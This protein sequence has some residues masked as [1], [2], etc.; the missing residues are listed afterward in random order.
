MLNIRIQFLKDEIN[1][2]NHN[3][4]VND[5]PTISDYEYD[6]LFAELKQIEADHPE[7]ITPDSPTQRVGSVSEKFL[8][9]THTHR[10]YSL[11]NTYNYEDLKDW[12]QKI[13]KE[14]GTDVELVCELKID[15]LAIA[16]T[17]ENGIFTRGVTRGDG[18]TGE[19][20]TQNLKTIKAIPLKLK[21]NVNL[22]VRGEIY[23]PK[24]SFEKLNEENLANGEKPFANPRNAAAGSLRQLDS[25][26]TAKRPLSFYAYY[27]GE[28]IGYD[29][30]GNQYD[31]L[32]EL[33][34]FGFPVNPNIKKVQGLIGLQEF[35]KDILSRRSLLN[36]DIDGVVLKVNSLSTQEQMGF[37]A[38]VPRWAIAYKFPP[39]EMMTKLLDVD[40]QV[41]RTGAVTPVA[42]LEPVYV[43]GVT[44]SSA[45]LHNED[46]IN[47]LG[48]KIGDTVIVRRAGDVIPQ[49]SGV[50]TEK[51]TG[52]EKEIVFPK[53][54]PECGSLIEKVEGEAVARCSGGLIC[55]AQ[56]REAV[57]HFVSR[58]AMDI[59]GF[60]DRIVDNLVSSGLVKTVDDLYTLSLTDLATLVLEGS[61][62]EKTR[63][64]GTVTATKLI[65][66]I[67]KSKTVPLNRFIYALGIREVGVTTARVLASNFETIDDLIRAK[68]ESLTA[69]PDIGPV[70]AQHIVDFFNEKHN[71]EVIGR[72]LKQDNADLFSNFGITLTALPQ[73]KDLNT[74]N[75][76]LLNQTYVITGTLESMDRNTAKA[77]LLNLGAK[78]SGSVS[79]KT[80]AV[81]C[82]ADPGSK[83][84]KA[85]ELEIKIIFEEEFLS[86]LSE[87]ENRN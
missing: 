38:K 11:D 29:L 46:E 63:L 65:D 1:K 41:G 84:T 39:E 33:K 23:M 3:Y 70:V 67:E 20:I 22:D 54:C 80:T 83:Y 76:P 21:D 2:H 6:K 60:G 12:Y 71:L 13:Q 52:N 49:V 72:L 74:D 5:N 28:C 73:V 18:V 53:Y 59:E 4:Y 85:Q 37:T 44:V 78:V 16:L 86:L 31:R 57:L 40:F 48:I 24:T 30:P 75:Q 35:Y 77:R 27:V 25:K 14:Y 34:K 26:I 36:Y 42:K 45:T 47:R 19:E 50:V 55:K 82:G 43:G 58:D 64:L 62:E 69:I 81:I 61:S 87:L 10:L 66:A 79:K 56:L 9:F 8:P 15:G 32:Q 7:L 68:L 17:Y 51:R